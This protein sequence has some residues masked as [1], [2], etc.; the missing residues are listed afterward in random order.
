MDGWHFDSVLTLYIQERRCSASDRLSDT[1]EVYLPVPEDLGN[2]ITESRAKLRDFIL[3][4]ETNIEN[5]EQ[6]I[7]RKRV[8]HTEV[9]VLKY[10]L[11][12]EISQVAQKLQDCGRGW[13]WNAESQQSGVPVEDIAKPESQAETVPLQQRKSKYMVQSAQAIRAA[14]QSG[15]LEAAKIEMSSLERRVHQLESELRQL[16]K[17]NLSKLQSVIEKDA[18]LICIQPRYCQNVLV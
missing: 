10:N 4:H 15:I 14:K 13:K 12:I 18:G 2:Q 5:M 1:E 8:S 17:K 7:L 11:E 16:E 6:L 3:Q 9:E